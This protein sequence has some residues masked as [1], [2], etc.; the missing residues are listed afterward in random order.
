MSGEKEWVMM[1]QTISQ[2]QAAQRGTAVHKMCEDY[3][4][5]Q[6]LAWLMSLKNISQKTFLRG[7]CSHR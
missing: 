1:L 4:N 2:E 3:L 7:V 6:H 5:N